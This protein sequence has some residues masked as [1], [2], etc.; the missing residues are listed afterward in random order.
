VKATALFGN[1]FV[2]DLMEGEGDSEVEGEDV[3]DGNG[4]SDDDGDTMTTT[5][6]LFPAPLKRPFKEIE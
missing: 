4:D 5:V 3:G 1:V 2:T 6:L